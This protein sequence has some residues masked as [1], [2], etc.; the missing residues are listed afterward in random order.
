VFPRA[1][2]VV[3]LWGV[4]G[5]VRRRDVAGTALLIRS[6]DTVWDL[7]PKSPPALQSASVHGIG[8]KVV[9]EVQDIPPSDGDAEIAGATDAKAIAITAVS[10]IAAIIL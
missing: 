4:C 9:S 1:S 3:L 2:H 7:E 6:L 8:P 10:V 5:S